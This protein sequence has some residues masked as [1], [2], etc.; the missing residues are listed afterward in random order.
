MGQTYHHQFGNMKTTWDFRARNVGEGK[1]HKKYTK[2]DIEEI[3]EQIKAY[4]NLRFTDEELEYLKTKCPWIHNDYINFLRFWHPQFKDFEISDDVDS[5]LRISFGGVQE[6]VSYYEI[7]VLEICAEVYYRNHFNYDELLKGFKEKTEEKI[8]DINFGDFDIGTW[9]EFGARRRLSFEAQDWLI[10]RLAEE[11]KK[12]S[13]F[14]GFVGTSNVFLAMKYGLT[15]VG[16]MA[17][18]FFQCIQ[19]GMPEV[20]PAYSNKLALDAWV[21]EY[22]VWNGIAL[23]D[24]LGTDLFLRDFGKTYSTLFSG[25]RNDSGDPFEWVDKMVE[26]Y[27]RLGVDSK[28]KTLLFSNNINSLELWDKLCRYTEGK[29]KPAFG[30]GTY[31]SGP[32]DID[33]LNI[34]AK[35]VLV[36]GRDVAKLSDDA[37]KCMCRNAEYISYLKR[38]IE[39]RLKHENNT[40]YYID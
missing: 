6:Y 16:T 17:H 18:E 30:I 34:V 13:R 23:T 14:I 38:T 24:T 19:S 3:T 2:E 28:Q 10:G 31:W 5:G 29:A 1:V 8:H 11:K 22:G 32:Q 4:C 27:R 15:P 26:H 35:V 20:N 37:G 36:N 33:P 7:P 12:S 39:W 25:V 9:S 21:K 40:N